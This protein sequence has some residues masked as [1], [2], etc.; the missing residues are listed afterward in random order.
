LEER[1]KRGLF[2]KFNQGGAKEDGG[3]SESDKQ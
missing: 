2:A 1:A 3:S